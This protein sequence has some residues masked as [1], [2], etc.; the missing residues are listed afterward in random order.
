L[1]EDNW[2]WSPQGLIAMHYPEMWGMVRFRDL[3]VTSDASEPTPFHLPEAEIRWQL[4][5]IYYRQKAWQARQG[6]FR[7]DLAALG[8]PELAASSACELHTTPTL[9]EA[10]M[11]TGEATLH[12]D[13]SGRLWRTAP[14]SR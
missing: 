8:F 5:Q 11:Q 4:M 2:V 7:D 1:P 14:A 3:P 12:V 9:F 10:R 13:Q 6:T